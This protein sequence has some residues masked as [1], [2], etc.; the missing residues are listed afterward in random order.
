MKPSEFLYIMDICKS[1]H[2]I[3]IGYAQKEMIFLYKEL[4]FQTARL[5]SGSIKLHSAQK[6]NNL[7]I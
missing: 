4:R 7:E 3:L 1:R 2:P 5:S 6:F